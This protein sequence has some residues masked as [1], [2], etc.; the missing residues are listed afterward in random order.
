MTVSQKMR[1]ESVVAEAI[2]CRVQSLSS[3]SSGTVKIQ[4][5]LAYLQGAVSFHSI[6]VKP[7]L[8]QNKVS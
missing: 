6:I 5:V 3:T 2:R 8:S 7:Y 4:N 1:D